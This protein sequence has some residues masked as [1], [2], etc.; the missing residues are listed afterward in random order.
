MLYNF[1]NKFELLFPGCTRDLLTYRI[2]YADKSEVVG[3]IVV[4]YWSFTI[5]SANFSS[6][7]LKYHHKEYLVVSVNRIKNID[8]KIVLRRENIV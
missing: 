8:F 1:K 2:Y 3:C 6:V 5:Q 4:H 7:T